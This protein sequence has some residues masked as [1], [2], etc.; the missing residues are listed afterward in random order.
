VHAQCGVGVGGDGGG[1]RGGGVRV[2]TV[3]AEDIGELGLLGGGEPGVHPP[4]DRDLRADQLVLVGHRDVLPG[5]HRERPGYQGRHAGQHDGVRGR[6]AAAEPGDQ[7][8]VGHQPVHRSE[9]RRPQPAAGH[10]TVPVRP[11][12]R[13][14]RPPHRPARVSWFLI[15]AADYP[16]PR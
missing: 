3:A 10:V 13:Q 15:H 8:G 6:A 2:G 11:P 1:H 14:R 5:A 7:R 4:L 12:R 9:Y 16:S